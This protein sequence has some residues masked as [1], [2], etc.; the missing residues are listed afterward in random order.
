M[1]PEA[2]VHPACEVSPLAKPALSERSESNGLGRDDTELWNQV[3]WKR[4]GDAHDP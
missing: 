1:S 3:S 2:Q 4:A